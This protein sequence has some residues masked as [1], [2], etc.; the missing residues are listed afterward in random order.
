M[1]KKIFVYLGTAVLTMAI[2]ATLATAQAPK[3]KVGDRVEASQNAACLGAQYATP[4]NGTITQVN[5]SGGNYVIQPDPAGGQVPSS[6]AR[7]ISS[8]VCGIR[9]L[10][11]DAPVIPSANLKTDSGNTV[12]ADRELLDCDDLDRT[13]KNGIAPSQELVVALIR[14]LFEK[15][16]KQGMDG[17]MTMD[18]TAIGIGKPHLWREKIDIGQGAEDTLVYPVRAIW[19]TRKFYRTRQIVTTGREGSFSCFSDADKL[20]QCGF[21]AGPSKDGRTEEVIVQN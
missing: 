20:W 16:S 19:N 17:A 7:P 9:L 13:G 3:F 2:S 18:V 14:C 5:T 8:Q 21:A 6:F 11:G 4:V 12:I 15:P 1:N 10:A